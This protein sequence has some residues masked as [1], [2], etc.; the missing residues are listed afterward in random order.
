M[1]FR[2]KRVA[3]FNRWPSVLVDIWRRRKLLSVRLRVTPRHRRTRSEVKSAGDASFALRAPVPAARSAWQRRISVSLIAS[4]FAGLLCD[5]GSAGAA[6][7]T[8]SG[9]VT[10][11]TE[12]MESFI[13]IATMC[14]FLPLGLAG[15]LDN[16]QVV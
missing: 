12:E 1:R 9:R 13:A 5:R 10:A 4:T 15:A 8:A 16:C 3:A 2:R 11:A 6:R 7:G 14:G